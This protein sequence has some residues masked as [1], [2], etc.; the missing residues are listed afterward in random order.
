[1]VILSEGSRCFEHAGRAGVES[2]TC[3]RCLK[4]TLRSLGQWPWPTPCCACARP[5]EKTDLHAIWLDFRKCVGCLKNA[6]FYDTPKRLIGGGVRIGQ[7]NGMESGSENGTKILQIMLGRARR[8]ANEATLMVNRELHTCRA[9][10]AATRDSVNALRF[11][12][13]PDSWINYLE[14]FHRWFLDKFRKR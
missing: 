14:Q 13:S 3:W 10:V 11:F 9:P 2:N 7:G 4:E 1:M 12:C 8:N 6:T 5:S